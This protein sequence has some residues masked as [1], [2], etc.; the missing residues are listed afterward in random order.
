[1][2]G[3]SPEYIEFL[4]TRIS[5]NVKTEVAEM[6]LE[7]ALTPEEHQKSLNL[8]RHYC[9]D[10]KYSVQNPKIFLVISQ[11]G[12]G[13]SGLTVRILKNNPNTVIIDSDAFKAF[14][15]RKDEIT[16]KYPTLY[17]FLTGLD[18]YLHRDEIYNQAIKNGYN[19]L[20]E[21]APSTKEKLF[22]IDFEELSRHGYTVDANILAVSRINSLI[23]VHERFEGQIEAGMD[24]PKLTD[25]KRAND[26]YDAVVLVLDDLLKMDDVKLSI[27]KRAQEDYEVDRYSTNNL[28]I[29]DQSLVEKD[30]YPELVTTDKNNA[31][32]L[33]IQAREEDEKI[34]LQNADE[35]IKT[36]KRQME[37]RHA[38][39][40]QR[41]QLSKIEEIVYDTHKNY[42]K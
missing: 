19:I 40:D 20:I 25:L 37:T 24:A 41:A 6:M 7:Y 28:F 18:A 29:I 13:K 32:A 42:D 22:N 35:R 27:W 38:P 9:F 30:R 36:I 8:I 10:N 21:I 3:K 17:G 33:F 34:T 16:K 14:N 5:P 15:P 31:R 4:K 1:M 11:T 2:E 12:G 39:T 26:S 23:S